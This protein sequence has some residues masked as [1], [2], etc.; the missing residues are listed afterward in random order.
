MTGC[1]KVPDLAGIGG[2]YNIV[3]PD[4]DLAIALRA[5]NPPSYWHLE[6]KPAADALSVSEAQRIPGLHVRAGASEYWFARELHASLLAMPYLSWSW[7]SNLPPAGP[8]PIRLVVGFANVDAPKKAPWWS[9]MS[10]DFPRADRIVAIEWADT[11]LGRGTVIGP[12]RSK[13]KYSYARY[14]ARGGPEH[15][16]RWWN[17]NV[18]LSLLHRQ[19]WPAHPVK[20]TEI[21]FIGIWSGKTKDPASMY[22]AN[23]RLFR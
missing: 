22:L 11:A 2:T 20:N 15:G 10:S 1:A 7:L 6:G 23:L 18:D 21:R 13:D 9:V 12:M 3:G 16:N 5:G 17:D 14:I 4:R 8:H 19:L